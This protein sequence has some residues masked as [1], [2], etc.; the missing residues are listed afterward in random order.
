MSGDMKPFSRRTRIILSVVVW[1]FLAPL[2]W[3][4]SQFAWWLGVG[5]AVLSIWMT[6]DYIKRGN[7]ASEIEEG[8]SRGAAAFGEGASDVLGHDDRE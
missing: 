1:I 5:V 2:I 3:G 8:L 6:Y 4:F 7:L